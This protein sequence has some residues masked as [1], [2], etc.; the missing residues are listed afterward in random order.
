M[1]SNSYL[2]D[3]LLTQIAERCKRD[4]DPLRSFITELDSIYPDK[5]I[6]F[7]KEQIRPKLRHLVQKTMY[8]LYGT[9][10]VTNDDI[11]LVTDILLDYL[12]RQAISSVV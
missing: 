12:F 6:E 8:E 5:F 2:L 7:C 11:D 4:P 10:N 3:M 9:N 1:I